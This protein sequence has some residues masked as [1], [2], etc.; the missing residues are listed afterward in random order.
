MAD[1]PYIPENDQTPFWRMRQERNKLLAECDYM[2]LPD[3]G[4]S[5]SKLNEWKTY[6]QELRDLPKTQTEPKLDYTNGDLIN[7][8]FPTKP[9]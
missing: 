2:V 1:T 3:R 7:V 6:R 8:T 9:E 5:E 4:L